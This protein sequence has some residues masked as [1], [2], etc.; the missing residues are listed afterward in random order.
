MKAWL[1]IELKTESL[2]GSGRSV[3]G[4]VDQEVLH[5]EYGFPFY[6]AKAVKGHLREQAEFVARALGNTG[7]KQE[8]EDIVRKCF[9][10]GSLDQ[11]LSG[12]VRLTDAQVRSSIREP[13]RQAVLSGEITAHDVLN[14]L[15]TVR[16]FTAIDDVTGSVEPETLRQFRMV[17]PPL[18]LE[19][20][21]DGLDSLTEHEIG[22]LAAAAASLRYIGTMKH[23]GKGEVRCRLMIENVDKTYHYIEQLKKWVTTA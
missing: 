15:T 17:R 19:A 10:T 9:G 13:F 5:D 6:R 23:R 1:K 22:L 8:L 2:F 12:V 16:F 11:V 7:R 4:E 21:V 3:P 14:A 18:E 20:H